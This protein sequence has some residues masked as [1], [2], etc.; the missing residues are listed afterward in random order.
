L[1][2]DADFFLSWLPRQLEEVRASRNVSTEVTLLVEVA[3]ASY[4]VR[5][6]PSE[7]SVQE[8]AIPS[9][10]FRARLDRS[11]FERLLSGAD[12]RSLGDGAAAKLLLLDAETVDL[13]AR[14]SGCLEVRFE[15][16]D[17]VYSVV[18]GPGMLD[19][20]GCTI[21]CAL[22]D[23]EQVQAGTVQPFELLMNGKLRIEGDP[24]IALALG[25][26]F[27]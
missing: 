26:L 6:S 2:T 16:G 1:L 19:E 20:V 8:S 9:P 7:A 24:Q 23:V 5:L 14:V 17:A 18:F 21:S 3:G 11:S 13:V 27:S 25:G 22:A 12:T 4:T 15:E 10:T